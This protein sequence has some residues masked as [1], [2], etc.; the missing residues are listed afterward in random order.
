MI[1]LF[2]RAFLGAALLIFGLAGLCGAEPDLT[3]ATASAPPVSGQ[4]IVDQFGWRAYAPCKVVLFAQPIKGQN[5]V[6]DAL[7]YAPDTTCQVRDTAPVFTGPVT[8]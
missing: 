8:V 7:T 4:I 6:G 1:C 2:S 5:A 3:P